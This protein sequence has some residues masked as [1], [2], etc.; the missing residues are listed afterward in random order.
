MYVFFVGTQGNFKIILK[1]S[2]SLVHTAIAIPAIL[3][4]DELPLAEGEEHTTSK[5]GSW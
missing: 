2:A 3:A 4:H 5:E 1:C